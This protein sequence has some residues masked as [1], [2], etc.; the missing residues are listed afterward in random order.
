M[1]TALQDI[2]HFNPMTF[3]AASRNT[4][5][6]SLMQRIWIKGVH[7]AGGARLNFES[8]AGPV[9]HIG[10]RLFCGRLCGSTLASLWFIFTEVAKFRFS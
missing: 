4:W 8:L 5:H 2:S 9:H 6:R 1:Y 3:L 7:L 10:D